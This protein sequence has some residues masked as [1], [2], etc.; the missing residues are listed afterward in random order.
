MS[1]YIDRTRAIRQGEELDRERL[2][3]Y[4]QRELSDATELEVE[5]FPGGHSNLTYLVR[6]AGQ[7]FVLRRPPFGTKAKSAHDM[8]R[9]YKVLSALAPHYPKAP[10]PALFCQDESIIGTPFYLME[11]V[12]GVILRK[13]LPNGLSLSA[14]QA[15]RLSEVLV[16]TLVELHAL[17]YRALGLANFGKPEGYVARQISGWSERYD[18]ARTEDLATAPR[19]ATW[20]DANQPADGKAALIHNDFKFDNIVVSPATLTDVV[21]VLDWEMSTVGDPLMDLGTTL[22]YWV[23]SKDS[24]PMQ[25]LRM[26]PTHLPGMLNRRAVA[27]RYAARSGR[28]LEHIVFY[29][30]FGLFKTAVIAQQIYARYAKGHSKDPRFAQM[31][32]AVRV[33]L[34]QAERAIDSKSL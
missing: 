6:V 32:Y 8:G 1:D 25:M 10:K 3:T 30:V 26:G 20:L 24:Q 16:D 12:R 5:Q 22:G 23:D 29:Y 7:E 34:D 21:G 31:I 2:L 19:V 15:Q 11:R 17:D 13:A 14:E 28:S 18:N 9:E 27:E 33:L 4:L